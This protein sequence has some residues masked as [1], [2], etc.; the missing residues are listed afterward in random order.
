MHSWRA[1][2]NVCSSWRKRE[3]DSPKRMQKAERNGKDHRSE[4]LMTQEEEKNMLMP[5]TELS[6]LGN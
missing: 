3:T 4:N 6:S 1:P 2:Q 5:N